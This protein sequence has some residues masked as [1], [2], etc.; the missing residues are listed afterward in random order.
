MRRLGPPLALSLL[1]SPAL[2]AAISPPPHE[3]IH[4]VAEHVPES[5][6]DARYLA[7]PGLGRP[8]AAG[9]WR[10]SFELGG[11]TSTAGPF[12]LSGLMLAAAASYG[13]TERSGLQLFGFYDSFSIAGGPGD[14]VLGAAGLRGVPLDLPERARFSDPR[15]DVRHF[16]VG[17]AWLRRL[18]PASAPR[19]W[20]LAAGWM[21]DRL[22]VDGFRV[23]FEL[24]SGAD[25]GSTGT[26]D[27][28]SRATFATPFVSCEQYRPLGER[29]ALLPRAALGAPLPAGD[30]DARISGSGFDRSTRAGDGSP[31]RIGDGFFALGLGLERLPSGWEIDLGGALFYPAFERV[32]HA[33]VD[34]AY[35]LR[36]AWHLR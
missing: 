5:A 8:L 35:T 16:G 3:D 7:L 2:P 24:L 22:E 25:A 23:R 28:S 36:V 6:Q 11:A 10:T 32:T 33:G 34:R 14:D 31:G 13:F 9:S 29:W 19:P 21:L 18:S 27:H 17:A 26:L 1:C 12:D 30:F 20:T 15:G 4:F